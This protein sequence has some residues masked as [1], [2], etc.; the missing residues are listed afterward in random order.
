MTTPTE[1]DKRNSLALL[2][3]KKI[4]NYNYFLTLFQIYII[5]KKLIDYNTKKKQKVNRETGQTCSSSL[6]VAT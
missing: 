1:I 2:A 5:M 6:R 3:C 4:I